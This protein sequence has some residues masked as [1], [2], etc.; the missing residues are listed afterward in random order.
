MTKGR[1]RPSARPSHRHRTGRPPRSGLDRSRLHPVSVS[2]KSGSKLNILDITPRRKRYPQ[3]V[4]GTEAHVRDAD[5]RLQGHQA[6]AGSQ[7]A[8]TPSFSGPCSGGVLKEKDLARAYCTQ[9]QHLPCAACG[10]KMVSREATQALQ[11]HRVDV[12]AGVIRLGIP[13]LR[14]PGLLFDASSL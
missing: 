12:R 5:V 8:Q 13:Q 6:S 11:G 10:S 4:P 7:G 2:S 3:E 14:A 9:S 1:R